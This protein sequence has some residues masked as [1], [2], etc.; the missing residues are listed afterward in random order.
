MSIIEAGRQTR[1][2]ESVNWKSSA[3][4][5]KKEAPPAQDDSYISSQP[6]DPGLLPHKSFGGASTKVEPRV[7]AGYSQSSITRY[8]PVS[9]REL[10]GY[11]IPANEGSIAHICLTHSPYDEDEHLEAMKALMKGM[12]N[13]RFTILTHHAVDTESL[14]EKVKSWAD[15]GI[16]K[17]PDRVNVVN[18]EQTLSIW[19]QDSTLVIGDNV[20]R[21]DRK[22]WPGFGDMM[23]PEKLAELNPELKYRQTEGIFI[24]GGNQLATRDTLFVGSDAIAFM[25][26][27]MKKCPE[28]YDKIATELKIS[29]PWKME[30][31]DFA[32]LIIDKSFPHQKV[33]IVGHQGKQ[34]AFH[35]DMVMTPLGKRDPETGKKVM[36]VGDPSMA[37]NLLRDL[38]EHNP[39]QY[40]RYGI[41]LRQKLGTMN[42][43]LKLMDK[44]GW[45]PGN[46]LDKLMD[47][48]SADERRQE[49]LDAMAKGFQ[50]D[51]YRVERVPYLG[52]S[53]LDNVPWITYNNVVIDG[54][55]VFMP[56]FGIP[57]LDN[58]GGAAYKKF[59]YSPVPL[60]MT[61]ISSG[62]G[63]INC[64][65]KVIERRYEDDPRVTQQEHSPRVPLRAHNC[66][67]KTRKRA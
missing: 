56:S 45:S 58:A 32:K 65:T 51:G 28:K 38:K 5:S 64:I 39:S 31:K 46:P 18:S 13:A 50:R 63:A 37:I 30:N 25:V 41:M 35:I 48:L 4:G 62:K 34:P 12:P 20:V 15:E 23:V 44:L 43:L 1:V 6:E 47:R 55:N 11:M 66:T 16:I 8:K 17:N 60:D 42:L 33:V 61:T 36:V 26:N 49:G 40:R 57:E 54:D 67:P 10:D 3:P 7:S 19:A 9:S 53:S 29:D 14:K 24:D 27:T 59:G 21:Q 2:G 52:D 22:W